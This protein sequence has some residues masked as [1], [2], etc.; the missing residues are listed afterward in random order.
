MVTRNRVAEAI[1]G[2]FQFELDTPAL[3]GVVLTFSRLV[4]TEPNTT[5]FAASGEEI[6]SLPAL[7]EN[8]ATCDGPLFGPF[9]LLARMRPFPTLFRY[10]E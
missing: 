6:V 10:R 8:A 1:K 2:E 9:W 5:D 3:C 7:S 4:E